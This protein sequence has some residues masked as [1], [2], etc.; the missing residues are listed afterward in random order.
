MN[1]NADTY[2]LNKFYLDLKS[3]SFDVKNIDFEDV[4]CLTINCINK[5][6]KRKDFI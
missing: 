4:F 2:Q 1:F 5:R 3:Y 6:K